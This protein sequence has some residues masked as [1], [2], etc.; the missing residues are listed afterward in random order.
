MMNKDFTARFRI[1][2]KLWKQFQRQ[3][4][5][6]GVKPSELIREYIVKFLGV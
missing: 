5:K 3:C 2:I 4:K 1:E 6:L